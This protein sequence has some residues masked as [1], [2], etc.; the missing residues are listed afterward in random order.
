MK[1]VE[2]FLKAPNIVTTSIP[3]MDSSI[4]LQI[5]MV[6]YLEGGEDE[7]EGLEICLELLMMI[8][9]KKNLSHII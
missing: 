8:L 5:G 7:A 1:N 3:L 6:I 4:H 9:H 2:I